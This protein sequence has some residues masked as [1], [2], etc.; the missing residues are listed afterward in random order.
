MGLTDN[1]NPIG[2][3]PFLTPGVGILSGR[4]R[5]SS[6]DKDGR[7]FPEPGIDPKDIHGGRTV[8]RMSFPSSLTGL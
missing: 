4:K 5:R 2:L 3:M 1:E 6:E 8:S 7:V